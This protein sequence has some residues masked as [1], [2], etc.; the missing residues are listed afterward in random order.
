M[1]LLVNNVIAHKSYYT[2]RKSWVARSAGVGEGRRN[3]NTRESPA[4]ESKHERET[5]SIYMEMISNA[6]Q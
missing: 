6:S 2:V 1:D 3:G 5:M 4:K